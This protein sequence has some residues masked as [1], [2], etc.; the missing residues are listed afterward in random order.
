[1]QA[2]SNL[3]VVIVKCRFPLYW[4]G[5][6]HIEQSATQAV[7]I[8]N[9][10]QKLPA[11]TAYQKKN[12]PRQ[13]QDRAKPDVADHPLSPGGT[14]L[15]I[16]DACVLLPP[17]L[18]DVLFDLSLNGLFMPHWTESIEAEFL[19]NW[20]KVV[21][22]GSH[23][24]TQNL[25]QNRLNCFRNATL[26]RYQ[27]FGEQSEALLAKVPA[28]VDLNDRHVVSAALAL[29]MA[30]E[31]SRDKIFIVTSNDVH[32][33]K[34]KLMKMGI[35]VVRPGVFIDALCSKAP[36]RVARTLA[37]VVSD[38]KNPPY[39]KE[40]LLGALLVHGARLTVKSMSARW[41][42]QPAPESR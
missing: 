31:D 7:Q 19:R 5:K 6:N 40:E 27:I 24:S 29:R 33:A 16:L 10:P 3:Q 36:L 22:S 14:T 9:L 34:S 1:M 18:S 23:L 35:S 8:T 38:L 42:L 11:C 13:D 30:S 39:T 2:A 17:R 4:N 15:A 25:A 12:I 21:K 28:E 26:N 20:K 41:K 37:K 32:M